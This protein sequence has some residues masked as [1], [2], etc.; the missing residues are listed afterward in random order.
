LSWNHKGWQGYIEKRDDPCIQG[1]WPYV[2]QNGWGGEW[3]N[4]N[5]TPG[6]PNQAGGRIYG[7]AS[8]S[9]SNSTDCKGVT[10]PVFKSFP[11]GDGV[12]IFVSTERCPSNGGRKIVGF[13]GKA[14]IHGLHLRYPR[15]V[16][17]NCR[18]I[19][20]FHSVVIGGGLLY[21]CTCGRKHELNVKK[22]EIRAYTIRCHLCSSPQILDQCTRNPLGPDPPT[23]CA[24]HDHRGPHVCINH[25]DPQV[26]SEIK[27]LW[28][29]PL[30]SGEI[31]Y[32]F[33][34][35][36]YIEAY[37]YIPCIENHTRANHFPYLIDRDITKTILQQ[38][39]QQQQQQQ[40]AN[41][42]RN[43]LAII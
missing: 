34:L 43:L 37:K 7:Y 31:A 5:M 6:F 29:E 12:I 22:A 16:C 10:R 20:I 25:H 8:M 33:K 11:Q 26:P 28:Y 27:D 39:L 41:K 19:F 9:A 15:L 24:S 2:Q 32:S 18:H 35:D 36:T 14:I 1:G 3:W 38:A 40:T 42:I 30:I 4:F 21:R 17:P 13:Y 23:L